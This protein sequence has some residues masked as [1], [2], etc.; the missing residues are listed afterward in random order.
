MVVLMASRACETQSGRHDEPD[1]R[2]LVLSL[3]KRKAAGIPHGEPPVAR[4]NLRVL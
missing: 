3:A 4:L 1:E 2:T